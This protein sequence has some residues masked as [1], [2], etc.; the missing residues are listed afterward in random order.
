METD[1]FPQGC[2]QFP[3][4]PLQGSWYCN[5]T[6]VVRYRRYPVLEF[7]ENEMAGIV[8]LVFVLAAF[9]GMTW[10]MD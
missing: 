4:A 9:A 10:I 6:R 5:H 3:V 1:N 2:V 7:W 8:V